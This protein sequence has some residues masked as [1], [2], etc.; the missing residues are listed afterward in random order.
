MAAGRD[1]LL[2][3]MRDGTGAG[4]EPVL[5]RALGLDENA[6][7]RVVARALVKAVADAHLAALEVRSGAPPVRESMA[8]GRVTTSGTQPPNDASFLARLG[9]ASAHSDERTG[10]YALADVRT[11]LAVMH[12]GALR[13]RR[14]AVR[15]LVQLVGDNAKERSADDLRAVIAALTASRDIELGYEV[16]EA[17]ASLPGPAARKERTDREPFA[18]AVAAASIALRHFWEGEDTTDWLAG[19]TSEQRALLLLRLRDVPDRLV[20]H[21]SAVLEGADGAAT[22]DARRMLATALRHAGDARLVPSL[23][24]LLLSTDSALGTEAARALRRIEDPRVAPL[25]QSAYERTVAEAPRAVLAGALG[26]TG[27]MGGAAHVRGLLIARD[28]SSLPAVLEALETLGGAEDV[29][30]VAG[31]LSHADSHLIASAVRTLGAMGD[32]RA[33]PGLAAL[34]GQPAHLG[35]RADVDAAVAAVHARMELRGEEA[36][37]AEISRDA[38]AA[39]AVAARSAAV[40]DPAAVRFRAG[41]DVFVGHAWLA[42]RAFVRAVARFEAAAARRPGWV[43]PLLAIG[44]TYARRGEVAQAIAAFRRAVAADR[45]EVERRALAVRALA[46]CFL[47]RADELERAGRTDIARGLLAE[48][49]ALDLRLT[50]SA[51]RFEVGRRHEALRRGG[52]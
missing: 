44:T 46:R 31:L 42:L 26:E 25:L 8:G 9:T 32:A 13:Q 4:D 45:S 16:S 51:L 47:L 2:R 29:E 49:G 11:V 48:L 43:T 21:L 19:L 52:P 12:A 6:E 5:R 23:G 14:A 30:A 38:A 10:V 37:R 15:R 3:A 50:G 7:D 1:E 20:D 18:E 22:L 17:L 27:E 33:L 41:W 35:M 36:P 28:E 34:R 40:S 24:A 39:A